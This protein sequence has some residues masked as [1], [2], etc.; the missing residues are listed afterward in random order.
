MLFFFQARE[1][2]RERAASSS[3]MF[4]SEQFDRGWIRATDHLFAGH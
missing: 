2:V 1:C 4:N 3:E